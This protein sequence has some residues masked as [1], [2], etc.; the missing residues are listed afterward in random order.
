[1]TASGRSHEL[2]RDDQ[3]VWLVVVAAKCFPLEVISHYEGRREGRK[4]PE[5]IPPVGTVTKLLLPPS[6]KDRTET[7]FCS[8]CREQKISATSAFK[9]VCFCHK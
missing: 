3:V 2:A 1:M 5:K 8:S 6:L 9:K 4:S 7:D